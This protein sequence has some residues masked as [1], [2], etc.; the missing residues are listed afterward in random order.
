VAVVVVEVAMAV[1]SFACVH[2][3][4]MYCAKTIGMSTPSEK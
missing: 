3:S 2:F 1:E 4:F